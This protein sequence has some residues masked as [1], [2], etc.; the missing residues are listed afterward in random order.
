LE[1]PNRV[2]CDVD[3]FDINPMAAWI[4]REEIQHLD[5]AA[6]HSAATEDCKE[7]SPMTGT[8]G[9]RNLGVRVAAAAARG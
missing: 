7:L 9:L 6:Y 8:L 2:G 1:Y 4:A 5:L 3:G